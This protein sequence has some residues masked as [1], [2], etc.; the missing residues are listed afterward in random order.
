[1]LSKLYCRRDLFLSVPI[2]TFKPTEIRTCYIVAHK[3]WLLG[4]PGQ[5][6]TRLPIA[7]FLLHRTFCGRCAV[8]CQTASD[9]NAEIYSP[10]LRN[11]FSVGAFSLLSER[12]FTGDHATSP[13]AGRHLALTWELIPVNA[14]RLKTTSW[15]IPYN[16]LYIMQL[17][18]NY[19]WFNVMD[20]LW[21]IVTAAS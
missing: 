11:I 6:D 3:W 8:K 17:K 10:F 12:S 21:T 15:A 7:P 18:K 4:Y 14:R 13:P 20:F 5:T 16:Y 9:Q 1:M 19:I 2:T